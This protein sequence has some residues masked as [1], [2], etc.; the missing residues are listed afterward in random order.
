MAGRRHAARLLWPN[1]KRSILETMRL[2]Q[3]HPIKLVFSGRKQPSQQSLDAHGTAA[4]EQRIRQPI[5]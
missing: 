2:Y 1:Q 5:V 4:R 3:E